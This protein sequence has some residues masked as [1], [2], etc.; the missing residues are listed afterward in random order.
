MD[1]PA[2]TPG[3]MAG[4]RPSAFKRVGWYLCARLAP[5]FASKS[6]QTNAPSPTTVGYRSQQ[7]SHT[8]KGR[9]DLTENPSAVV[10]CMIS[11][12][13]KLHNQDFQSLA[14]VL[15]ECIAAMRP[16]L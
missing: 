7:H 16:D 5:G 13:R 3:S 2:Q 10:Y 11:L 6:T 15:N 8:L 9:V 1:I 14:L 12:V 4:Q